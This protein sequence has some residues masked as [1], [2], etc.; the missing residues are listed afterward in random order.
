MPQIH[1]EPRRFIFSD[2][3][4]SERSTVKTL[5]VSNPGTARLRLETMYLAG[6]HSADFQ[7]VPGSCAGASFVAPG[8]SCTAGVRFVP[9][10]PGTRRARLLIPHGADGSPVELQLEGRGMER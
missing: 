4:V 2:L 8:A 7:L 3:Q 9:S 5:T 1:V 10:G 6:E